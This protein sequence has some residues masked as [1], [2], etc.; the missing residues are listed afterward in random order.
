MR[1]GEY[2]CPLG[3]SCC[4]SEK[5]YCC[6]SCGSKLLCNTGDVGKREALFA[7]DNITFYALDLNGDGKIDLREADAHY[8]RYGGA[9][10]L[11][12]SDFLAT[13]KNGDGIIE[14]EEFAED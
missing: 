10:A 6:A 2:C 4:D 8:A 12:V 13:D 1:C 11:R 3:K 7:D 14:L 9:E 5:R